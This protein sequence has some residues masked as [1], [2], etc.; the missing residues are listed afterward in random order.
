MLRLHTVLRFLN[1][2]TK[3]SCVMTCVSTDFSCNTKSPPTIANEKY[4][5]ALFMIFDAMSVS[6]LLNNP[7][8]VTE[9]LYSCFGVIFTTNYCQSITALK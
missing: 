2:L 3:H 1:F 4:H 8:D 6:M 7:T 9:Q 5:N